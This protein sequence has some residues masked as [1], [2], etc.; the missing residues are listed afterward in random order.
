MLYMST[1]Q[2]VGDGL[3]PDR[4]NRKLNSFQIRLRSRRVASPPCNEYSK[5]RDLGKPWN[6]EASRVQILQYISRYLPKPPGGNQ[7]KTSSDLRAAGDF[8]ELCFLLF[9]CT[10]HFQIPCFFP[11]NKAD[12]LAASRV[13]APKRGCFDPPQQTAGNLE[14]GTRTRLKPPEIKY[15]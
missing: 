4:L 1:F 9:R 7:S 8:L 6:A 5:E 13:V 15:Y 10:S 11:F 3:R 14:G 12:N 2:R